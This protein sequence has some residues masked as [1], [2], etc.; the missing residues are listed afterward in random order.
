MSKA[1]LI[2]PPFWD[3]VCPPLGA[4]SLK[5]FGEMNGNQINIVDLNTHTE[6]FGAQAEYFDEIQR[7]FPYMKKWNIERNGTEKI[8]RA[9]V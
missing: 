7:Q 1:L 4:A 2:T 8:G 6:I 3:P 5:S 9:H